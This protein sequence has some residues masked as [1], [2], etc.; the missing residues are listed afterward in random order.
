MPADLEHDMLLGDIRYRNMGLIGNPFRRYELDDS[1]GVGLVCHA[2]ACDLVS[3]LNDES[4]RERPR[5]LWVNKELPTGEYYHTVAV[6]EVLRSLARTDT[7]LL[8]IYMTLDVFRSGRIRGALGTVADAVSARQFDATLAA[9]AASVL[10]APDTELAEYAGIASVDLPALVERLQ[11]APGE[12]IGE[13][14]GALIYDRQPESA[15]DV[16][17]A[18][19]YATEEHLDRDPTE[20]EDSD[21][22]DADLSAAAP[23]DIALHAAGS[24]EEPPEIAAQDPHAM[25]QYLIA[26][27]RLHVSPVIARAL[28][29]YLVAGSAAVSEQL[30]I[31]K[32]PKKTLKALLS[33]ASHRYQKIVL[34]Y[35]RFDAWSEIDEDGRAL[36]VGTM[37]E[38]RWLVAE[39][40]M[41]VML[42]AADVAPDLEEQFGGARTGRVVASRSYRDEQ[43]AAAARRRARP[44]LDRRRES[45][46]LGA[47]QHRGAGAGSDRA[48]RGRASR[49]VCE[50][51]RH[52]GRRRREQGLVH[53]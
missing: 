10:S 28:D 19:A 2:E 24:D 47:V 16:R 17:Q 9:W 34:I 37:S 13:H 12:T 43:T 48:G 25:A 38:L 20:A 39:H 33:F 26:Y 41:L 51:R 29:G 8:G 3:A 11:T 7:P 31:T 52:G 22:M 44:V 49:A 42:V 21:E 5:P 1:I 36:V 32:A 4:L 18:A 23:P 40:G 14:F 46:R 50:A 35:D 45:R 30:R 15:G 6:S 27:A 53:S